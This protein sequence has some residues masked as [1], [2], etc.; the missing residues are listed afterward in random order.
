[1]IG[2]L[3]GVSPL[4]A[5][6]QASRG[7][8]RAGQATATS[9]RRGGFASSKGKRGGGGRNVGGYNV[10]TRFKADKWVK[11]PS[12][13]TTV[14]PMHKP[15]SYDPEG[16]LQMTEYKQD[17]DTKVPQRKSK[18]TFDEV[19]DANEDNFQ[20][21]WDSK[22]QWIE[23]AEKEIDEGYYEDTKIEAGKRWSRTYQVDKNGK[24]VPG[25]ESE[26]KVVGEAN[27]K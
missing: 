10:Q 22:E 16:N 14:I 17:P 11:P 15:Y 27:N 13:G 5:K 9:K 1:M 8:K 6:R 18:G 24:R 23:Q 25:S 19:W 2:I 12:G 20:D 21:K 7:G 4:K 26:W 3:G